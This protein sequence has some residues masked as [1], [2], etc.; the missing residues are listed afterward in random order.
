M[1]RQEAAFLNVRPRVV[2]TVH[3]AADHDI[4]RS[5]EIVSFLAIEQAS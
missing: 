1:K 4:T 3:R 2:N 5:A